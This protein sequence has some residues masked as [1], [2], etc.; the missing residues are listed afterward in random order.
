M[1]TFI[2][3]ALAIVVALG[4]VYAVTQLLSRPNAPVLIPTATKLVQD[5]DTAIKVARDNGGVDKVHPND[6]L[7]SDTLHIGKPFAVMSWFEK[8]RDDCVI[9]TMEI[10]LVNDATGTPIAIDASQLVSVRTPLGKHSVILPLELPPGA[11]IGKYTFRTFVHY[12][13]PKTT[14]IHEFPSRKVTLIP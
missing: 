6:V 4:V 3:A 13:C 14:V 12:K 10:S 1:R 7:G 11:V 5:R 2:N 9:S 8:K